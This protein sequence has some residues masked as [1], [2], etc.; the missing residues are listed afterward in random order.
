MMNVAAN[1]SWCDISVLLSRRPV[2]TMAMGKW[3]AHSVRCNSGET[4]VICPPCHTL[5]HMAAVRRVPMSPLCKC[6]LHMVE[7]EPPGV[8]FRVLEELVPNLDD[9]TCRYCVAAAADSSPTSVRDIRPELSY[10]FACHA[11]ELQETK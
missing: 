4:R 5:L 10:A 11:S 1:C 6:C 7:F 2:K 9:Y 3:T 8:S